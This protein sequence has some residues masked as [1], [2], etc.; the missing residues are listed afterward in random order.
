MKVFK[1]FVHHL[2]LK[3]RNM[4]SISAHIK[5]SVAEHIETCPE[6]FAVQKLV[7][8]KYVDFLICDERSGQEQLVPG[9]IPKWCIALDWE[10]RF[11]LIL[12]ASSQMM[13]SASKARSSFS[14]LHADS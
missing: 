14:N 12:W 4:I 13:R 8:R 1:K 3:N 2:F 9:F 10:V 6:N 5:I 11:S 7:L